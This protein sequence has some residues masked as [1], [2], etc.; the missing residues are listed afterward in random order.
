MYAASCILEMPADHSWRYSIIS[1]HVVLAEIAGRELKSEFLP[2][3]RVTFGQYMLS[4]RSDVKTES[5]IYYEIFDQSIYLLARTDKDQEI[6]LRGVN[7]TEK[8][9]ELEMGQEVTILQKFITAK[10][11]SWS[12]LPKGLTEAEDGTITGRP[13]EAGD[14]IVSG[15][16]GTKAY[17]YSRTFT[18]RVAQGVTPPTGLSATWADSTSMTLKINSAVTGNPK[19]TPDLIEF[20]IKNLRTMKSESKFIDGSAKETTIAGY[21]PGD[22]Y[23]VRVRALKASPILYSGYSEVIELKAQAPTQYFSSNLGALKLTQTWLEGSS[24]SIALTWPAT[25]GGQVQSRLP[26][27][28]KLSVTPGQAKSFSNYYPGLYMTNKGE[29][30][31]TIT[32]ADL[33]LKPLTMKIGTITFVFRFSK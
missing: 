25:V 24:T 7:P 33:A 26:R 29:I 10:K 27:G 16:F 3:A 9:L 4:G 23:K 21:L 28:S 2:A 6:R 1:D 11:I 12:G 31:G 8:L 15:A 30:T 19:T 32:K 5:N 18:I 14:F 22:S 13:T 17:P 20:D